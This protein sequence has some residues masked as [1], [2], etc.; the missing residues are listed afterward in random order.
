MEVLWFV[1]PSCMGML[2][3]FRLGWLASHNN[4]TNITTSEVGTLLSPWPQVL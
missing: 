2:D 3:R 4:T 1:Q